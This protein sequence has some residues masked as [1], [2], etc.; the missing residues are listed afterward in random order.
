MTDAA[1]RAAWDAC[2]RARSRDPMR[3]AQEMDVTVL[4]RGDFVA[5]KGAFS[6]VLGVPVSS[7]A[8]PRP[9]RITFSS[10]MAR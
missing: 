7:Q 2:R 10:P 8:M 4:T 6:M 5:Q 1:I 9:R 3:V